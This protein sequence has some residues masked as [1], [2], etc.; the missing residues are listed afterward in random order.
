[1]SADRQCVLVL[2]GCGFIGRHLVKLLQENDYF[3]RVVDKRTPSMADLNEEFEKYFDEENNKLVEYIQADLSREKS[4][5]RAFAPSEEHP[6]VTSFAFVFNLTAVTQLGH[7]K[8]IYDT[9]VLE[10]AR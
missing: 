10:S 2:G 3:V 5:E 6:E 4:A 1:M 9:N 8:Q 7:E